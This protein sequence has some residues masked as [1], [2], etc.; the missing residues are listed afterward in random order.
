[1]DS[2]PFTFGIKAAVVSED[3]GDLIVE[4]YA[5]DFETDRD[6][7]AFEPGAFSRGLAAYMAN[8]VL[9]E[10]HQPGKQLGV[11]EHAA[12]DAKGL[13]IRARLA[14]PPAGAWSEQTF[15]LVKRGMMKG[16]SVGGAFK[17]RSVD[18]LQKIFDVD[19]Q[20]ISITPLP[21][22]Q[23]TLFATAG[24][25]FSDPDPDADEKAIEAITRRIVLLQQVFDSLA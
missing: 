13:K 5:S 20:E 17:R 1:M 8:P 16:F 4:G 21:V 22:N 10:H 6:N 9:L 19:L 7:E 15:D 12:L 14:K 24:K 23:R 2:A 25:A 3:D 18:G 11:V